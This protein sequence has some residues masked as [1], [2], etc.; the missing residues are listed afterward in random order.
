MITLKSK[1]SSSG[2]LSCIT[3]F[4]T[5]ILAT[6]SN[7]YKHADGH[8]TFRTQVPEEWKGLRLLDS[9]D[10]VITLPW[11]TTIYQFTHHKIPEDWDLQMQFPLNYRIRADTSKK[12]K[13][14]KQ[15]NLSDSIRVKTLSRHFYDIVITWGISTFKSILKSG[16][17][18][19]PVPNDPITE[20]DDGF[21]N[22]KTPVISGTRGKGIFKFISFNH[23]WFVIW[24]ITSMNVTFWCMFD[25]ASLI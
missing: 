8:S 4:V 7:I 18:Q 23:V 13:W 2:T 22:L 20:T 3:S 11:N 9:Q 14:T 17:R 10:T 12:L 21:S 19:Q 15:T 6:P 25:C 5:V 1:N 24:K 16:P